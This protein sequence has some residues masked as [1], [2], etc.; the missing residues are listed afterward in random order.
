MSEVHYKA[1]AAGAA[2]R[3]AI[4]LLDDMTLIYQDIGG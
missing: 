3:R 2:I 1:E 4:Q